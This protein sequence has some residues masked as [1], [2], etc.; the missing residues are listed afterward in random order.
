MKKETFERETFAELIHRKFPAGIENLSEMLDVSPH[1][2]TKVYNGKHTH[3]GHKEITKWAELLEEEPA[4][5]ISAYGVGRS[6][7]TLD[8]CEYF[9]RQAGASFEVPPALPHAA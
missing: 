7:L 5:L 3:I 8:D 9:Y 6:V 1:W 2:F 4:H